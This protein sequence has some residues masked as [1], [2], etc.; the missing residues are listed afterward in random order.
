MLVTFIWSLLE[1]IYNEF[2]FLPLVIL[3]FVECYDFS[4]LFSWKFC[5]HEAFMAVPMTK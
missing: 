3:K 2:P 5:L 4:Y 1:S